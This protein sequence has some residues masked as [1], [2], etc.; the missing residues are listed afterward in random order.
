M[1]WLATTVLSMQ[2]FFSFALHEAKVKR[3][4]ASKLPSFDAQ[5]CGRLIFIPDMDLIQSKNQ[6]NLAITVSLRNPPSG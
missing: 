2:S 5:R 1:K 4:Q 6:V 3:F